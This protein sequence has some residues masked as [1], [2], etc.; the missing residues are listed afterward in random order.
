[1]VRDNAARGE[2]EIRPRKVGEAIQ[3][4]LS[5]E[6]REFAQTRWSDA[7]SS[8][9]ARRSWAGVRFGSRV[10]DSRY[11]DVAC[12]P[13][14]AFRPIR[15]IGGHV[16]WYFGDWLWHL[17]GFLDLLAGGAGSRRG[18]RDPE[19]LAAGDTVDFW[20]VERIEPDR[21]LHLRAEMKLPGR[22][23]LQFEATPL[24][25]GGCRI[26]QTAIFDPVGL[27][28]LLYWYGLY[29][30]HFLIFRE[31]LRGIARSA[32]RQVAATGTGSTLSKERDPL[33]QT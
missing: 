19:H 14:E 9:S 24:S 30:L 16:G 13:R 31:M 33:Q 27:F 5:N 32:L 7:L 2:F 15:R 28:G 12:A 6:D 26:R 1:M 8:T 21:L 20:R 22:A 23:W 3:R 25:G 17:R 18:R 4:A 11:V 10:I 29:P